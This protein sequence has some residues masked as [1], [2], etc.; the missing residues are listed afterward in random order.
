MYASHDGSKSN[1]KK[2]TRATTKGT[3]HLCPIRLITIPKMPSNTSTIE[4]NIST[5]HRGA[6]LVWGHDPLKLIL[7]YPPAPP[8]LPPP[9]PPK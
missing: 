8:A 5:N 2:S 1:D 4:V 7:T 3:A 6:T 9:D